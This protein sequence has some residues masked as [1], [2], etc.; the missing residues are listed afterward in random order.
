MNAIHPNWHAILLH[1]PLALLVT[2][3]LVELAGGLGLRGVLRSAGRWMILLGTLVAVPTATAGVYALR[4]Q[5]EGGQVDVARTWHD[6]RTTG[7]FTPAQWTTLG[8]HAWLNVGAVAVALG[9]VGIWFATAESA[10]ARL[11]APLRAALVVTLILLAIGGWYGGDAVYRHGTAVEAAKT[12]N[13]AIVDAA[14]HR[15]P[16]APPGAADSFSALQLHVV[17]AGFAVALAF[18]ALVAASWRWRLATNVG[19]TAAVEMAPELRAR[20]PLWSAAVVGLAL[21]ALLGT[22]SVGGGLSGIP[23]AVAFA[24]ERGH[25]RL[26][27]HVLLGV[28]ALLACATPLVAPKLLARR[29]GLA[30]FLAVLIPIA[31]VAQLALGALILFDS[32]G[33]PLVG[34]N[35]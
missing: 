22:L 24:F 19:P 2:G 20:R 30:T 27:V 13:V 16:V 14:A 8:W 9:T 15:S 18:A 10:R 32:A 6:L 33:G 31:A 23:G 7:A 28:G 29:T 26:L 17:A 12:G 25:G 34:T 4:S 3:I 1:F 11:V 21:T 35:P 5:A